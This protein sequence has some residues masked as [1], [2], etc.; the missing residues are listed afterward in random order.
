MRGSLLA[1]LW[2]DRSGLAATEFAMLAPVLVFMVLAALDLTTAL[3]ERMA[4]GHVLR[5]GAQV[6][7]ADPGPA[8]VRAAMQ[9]MAEGFRLGTDTAGGELSL[10]AELRCA[11]P[12]APQTA[13]SCG[14][15]GTVCAGNQPTTIAYR[16]QARKN[17]DS[18]LLPD[19]ASAMLLE[20]QIR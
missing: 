7:M 2:Q 14:T 3:T 18:R 1:R 4:I 16:L 17:H 15:G 11:C 9:G 19:M 6:A 5:S 13:V 20:V 8:Q 10:T 12:A